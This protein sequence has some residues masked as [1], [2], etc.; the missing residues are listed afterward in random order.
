MWPVYVVGLTNYV[1]DLTI[2][3][4]HANSFKGWGSSHESSM[5]STMYSKDA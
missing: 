5:H 4:T 1:V 3:N 2:P